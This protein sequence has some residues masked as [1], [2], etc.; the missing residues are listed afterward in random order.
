MFSPVITPEGRELPYGLGWFSERHEGTRLVWHYGW[1]PPAASALYL[2]L[3]DEG[4]TFLALANTDALSRPFDLGRGD[5]SV[6]DSVVAM[7]FYETFVGEALRGRSLPRIDWEANPDS[8]I[9]ALRGAPGEGIA[10]VRER[11]LLAYR[12][13]FYATGRTDRVASLG[14]VHRR[15]RGQW[16]PAT[17]GALPPL[18]GHLLPWPT[19]PLFGMWHLGALA[20]FL[21]VSLW[22]LVGGAGR[23]VGAR[24]RSRG[25]PRPMRR[26]GGRVTTALAGVAVVA[27][28][29]LYLALLSRWPHEGPVAWSAGGLLARGFLVTAVMGGVLSVAALIQALIPG[30]TGSRLARVSRVVSVS[31]VFVGAWALLDLAGWIS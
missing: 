5:R 3:P 8:L 22:M 27:G 13:L 18:G 15:L 14:V 28:S 30:P 16:A 12:R 23:A 17:P 4:L 31:G 6:L 20:W 29:V 25:E 9:A 2:K 24:L 10:E 11:E 1:G 7:L 21:M 26:S 19:V